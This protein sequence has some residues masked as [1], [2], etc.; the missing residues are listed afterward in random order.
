MELWRLFAHNHWYTLN[1][2]GRELRLC[3]RCSGYVFGLM[4]FMLYSEL[5]GLPFMLFNSIYIKYVIIL[6]SFPFILDWVT[7]SWGLRNS[8]NLIRIFT[9]TLMGFG[10]GVFSQVSMNFQTKR[11]IFIFIIFS[12]LLSGRVIKAK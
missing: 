6:L 7:Q 10:I 5:L 9:G 11:I 1:L 2:F 12:V 8:T 4:S 3:A